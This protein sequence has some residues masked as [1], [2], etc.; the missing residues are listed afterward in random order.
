[1]KV[2]EKLYELRKE[3]NLSQEE[4][5]NKL[6]VSRQTVSKWE[7]DQSTPDFDKIAPLCELYQISADDL[8][9]L[10]TKENNKGLKEDKKN[11]KNKK[12][13]VITL[14]TSLYF[15]AVIYV[16]MASEVW[17]FGDALIACGFLGICMFA[18][19]LLIYYF[20]SHPNEEKIEK[21]KLKEKEEPKNKI[22]DLVISI[23]SII[24]VIVYLTISFKTMAW[25]ITWI[26]WI[27]FALIVEI[28]KLVFQILGGKNDR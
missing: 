12:A 19:A 28:I 4:V 27:I 22:C 1:M 15:L 13:L 25:H 26:I 5:A 17:L 7:T 2:S 21:K 9:N 6:N 16:I 18:S 20:V 14:S 10:G 3:A 11:G 23:V 8:L 24:T